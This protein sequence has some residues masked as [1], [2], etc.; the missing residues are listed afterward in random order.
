[1]AFVPELLPDDELDTRIIFEVARCNAQN[2]F[3]KDMA[4]PELYRTMRTCNMQPSDE[5]ILTNGFL[6][7]Q[8]LEEI[9][10]DM[11]WKILVDFWTEMMLY[12]APSTNAKA[13]IEHLANGGEFLT[14][15]WALLLHAGILEREQNTFDEEDTITTV[16]V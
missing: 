7:G 5:R 14:H 10:D 4:L 13:H 9:A 16:K 3:P 1:M 2:M 6:L 11:H 15:L 8:Q 12:I